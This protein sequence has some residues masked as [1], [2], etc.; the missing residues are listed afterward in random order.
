MKRAAVDWDR[1]RSRLR[2]SER[3]LE[4]ALAESPE[5]IAIAYRQRARRLAS[6]QSEPVP[7]SAGLPA[8][9]FRLAR[10][11]YAIEL[12][13]VSEALPY[14]RCTRPPGSP[15]QFRGVMNLRGELR[16]VLDLAVLLA[17]FEN[18]SRDSGFVLMLRRPGR[19]IGL[20]VDSV[21]EL[22]ELRLEE[23]SVPAR[24]S[25]VKGIASGALMLLDVEAVLAAVFSKE[26]S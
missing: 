23:L 6:V 22:R 13:E 11:R 26:E 19:E 9:V 5:R 10:E 12:A 25:Y 15:P 1:V 14:V 4:E 17:I 2:S 21:E 16:A 8:L 3:A 20:K 18:G 7:V 24:G